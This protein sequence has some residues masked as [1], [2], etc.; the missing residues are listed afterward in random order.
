MLKK[1]CNTNIEFAGVGGLFAITGLLKYLWNK[2]FPE[3][4]GWKKITYWQSVMLYLVGKTLFDSRFSIRDSFNVGHNTFNPKSKSEKDK[5]LDCENFDYD[6]NHD[7]EINCDDDV[8]EVEI[9]IKSEHDGEPE[10]I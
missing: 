7:P 8:E 1:K 2:L 5:P 3:L 4:F 6:F 10:T 9:E